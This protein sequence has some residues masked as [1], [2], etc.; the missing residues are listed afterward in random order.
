MSCFGGRRHSA[1]SQGSKKGHGEKKRN[2]DI[3][4][5]IQSDRRKES[6]E[7]KIL[8]LGRS[9]YLSCVLPILMVV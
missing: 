2:D 4:K 9:Q 7:V 1:S 3:N 6:K 8:L 5:K